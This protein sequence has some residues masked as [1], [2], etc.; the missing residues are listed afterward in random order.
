MATIIHRGI[1]KCRDV[2]IKNDLKIFSQ[3]L[4]HRVPVLS[5]GLFTYDWTLMY[6]L[7]SAITT[8]LVILIQFDSSFRTHSNE[9][10]AIDICNEV[11]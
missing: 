4:I 1:N 5:C 10:E 8:Y 11:K 9:T 6:S 7:A 3:Q 2:Q